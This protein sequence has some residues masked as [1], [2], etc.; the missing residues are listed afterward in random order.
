[1]T[2]GSGVMPIHSVLSKVLPL[3]RHE[4]PAVDL[5]LRELLPQ[6]QSRMLREGL[7]DVG[8]LIPPFDQVDLASEVVFND[9]LV[10]VL[11]SDHVLAKKRSMDLRDLTNERFVMPTRAWAPTYYDHLVMVCRE[12]GFSPNIVHTAAELRTIFTLVAAGLGTALGTASTR[13]SSV[14]GVTYVP[15]RA[16]T[17]PVWMAWRSSNTN[18]LVKEFIEL[19]RSNSA[20]I[21]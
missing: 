9:P 2:V 14:D 15:V 6:E 19:V 16:A 8:F 5:R 21:A 3:F 12:A 10:A 13:T 18:P 1:L 11:P 4:F 7:T 20:A 17:V